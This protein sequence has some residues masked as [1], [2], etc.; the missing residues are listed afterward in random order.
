MAAKPG[1]ALAL[2]A[3][4]ALFLMARKKGSADDVD[5]TDPDAVDEVPDGAEVPDETPDKPGSPNSGGKKVPKGTGA[6]GGSWD[7]GKVGPRELWISPNCESVVEGDEYYEEVLRP[8]VIQVMQD[9]I[10]LQAKPD[11]KGS[12]MEADIYSY[13][14]VAMGMMELNQNPTNTDSPLFLV[15]TADYMGKVPMRCVYEWPPFRIVERFGSLATNQDRLDYN[16][17]L[18]AYMAD[19]PQLFM[20]LYSLQERLLAD[21]AQLPATKTFGTFDLGI[22]VFAPASGGPATPPEEAPSLGV[23][24]LVDIA[25]LNDWYNQ[26][27]AYTA[28][29]SQQQYK[30]VVDAIEGFNVKWFVDATGSGSAPAIPITT[31]TEQLFTAAS[32]TGFTP[33]TH[34]ILVGRVMNPVPGGPAAGVLV[35]S[36]TNQA[37]TD[38]EGIFE[39]ALP[40]GMNQ[41]EISS[42]PAVLEANVEIPASQSILKD[43]V[44]PS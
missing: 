15:S 38:S 27:K 23:L 5:M 24:D 26:T 18:Q 44:L 39:L 7:P 35:R 42:G 31:P 19:Y 10:D 21:R 22:S 34:G 33:A 28:K 12:I 4:G 29:Y 43:L 6:N 13:M 16:E 36:G 37:T 8:A 41:L 25:K 14:A 1:P 40:V 17:D 9:Q 11:W 20:K 2:A 32:A 3:L 30:K